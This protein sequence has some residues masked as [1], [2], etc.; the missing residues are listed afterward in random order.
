M[1]RRNIF[2]YK[3]RAERFGEEADNLLRHKYPT[4]T[5]KDKKEQ[6]RIFDNVIKEELG[7]NDTIFVLSVLNNRVTKKAINFKQNPTIKPILL[8]HS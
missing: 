2:T 3:S 8:N 6:Q 5:I 4:T 7:Q 1:I